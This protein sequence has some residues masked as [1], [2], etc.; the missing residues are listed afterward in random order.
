MEKVSDALFYSASN[1][2][3]E[4]NLFGGK[5]LSILFSVKNPNQGTEKSVYG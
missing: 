1:D 3:I 4:K 5:H 2:I